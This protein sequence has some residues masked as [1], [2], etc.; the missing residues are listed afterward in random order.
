MPAQRRVVF[1]LQ[2]PNFSGADALM[3]QGRLVLFSDV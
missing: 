3:R 1:L 2:L